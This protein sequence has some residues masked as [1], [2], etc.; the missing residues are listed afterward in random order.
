NKIERKRSLIEVFSPAF[1]HGFTE[2]GIQRSVIPVGF[3]LVPDDSAKGQVP[4]GM[5]HSIVDQGGPL[6]GA[7]DVLALLARIIPVRLQVFFA[8]RGIGLQYL[9][10][11]KSLSACA[12][13]AAYHQSH[14]HTEPVK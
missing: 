14:G 11:G 5:D 3:P 10:A 12:G 9:A 1:Q 7:E 4:E 13:Q 2:A 6:Q 8:K